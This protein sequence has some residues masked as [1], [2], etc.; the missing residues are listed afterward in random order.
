MHVRSVAAIS[1]VSGV[2]AAEL[3][4]PT[5]VTSV[6]DKDI[7]HQFCCCVA[8]TRDIYLTMDAPMSYAAGQGMECK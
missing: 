1:V 4:R 3:P 2:E 6:S 5:Y 8:H 7:T